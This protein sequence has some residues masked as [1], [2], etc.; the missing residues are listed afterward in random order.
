MRAST[1]SLALYVSLAAP[2]GADSC[3]WVDTQPFDLGSGLTEGGICS[4]P[5]DRV[6]RWAF[7]YR[8]QAAESAFERI[9][10]DLARCLGAPAA[11]DEP[12]N[13]P[14]SYQLVQFNGSDGII[15]VSLKDKASLQQTF[16]FLRVDNFRN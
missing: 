12:V 1:I 15:S 10:N 2:A 7:K 9:A 6:C 5:P 8:S 14:D 11:T 3:D 13:H 4:D 16:V